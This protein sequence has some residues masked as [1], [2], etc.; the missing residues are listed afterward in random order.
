MFNRL[1]EKDTFD[2]KKTYIQVYASEI[3]KIV[4]AG[5]A[6]TREYVPQCNCTWEEMKS[7]KFPS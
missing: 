6:S 2:G 3:V 4:V 5:E 1:S 7:A